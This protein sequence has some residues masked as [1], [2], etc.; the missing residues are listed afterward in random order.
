MILNSYLYNKNLERKK[1][2]ELFNDLQSLIPKT[3][4]TSIIYNI[5]QDINEKEQEYKK[6]SIKNKKEKLKDELNDLFN[7]KEEVE[8]KEEREEEVEEK[9]E[10]EELEGEELEKLIVINND[11]SEIDEQI[12]EIDEG[13]EEEKVE[14]DEE[15]KEEPDGKKEGGQPSNI[16][17][18]VVTNFF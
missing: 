13:N 17:T 10:T 3:P 11:G 12:V 7:E 6:V 1:K 2:K 9:E 18:V 14:G 4:I 8:E 15:D 5:Q 16:K